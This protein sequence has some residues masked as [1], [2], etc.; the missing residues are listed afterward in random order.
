MP[1][2]RPIQEVFLLRESCQTFRDERGDRLLRPERAAGHEGAIHAKCQIRRLVEM[3]N[4][5]SIP[6]ISLQINPRLPVDLGK[7]PQ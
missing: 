2:A 1:G 5:D 6:S 3:V 4:P 7:G